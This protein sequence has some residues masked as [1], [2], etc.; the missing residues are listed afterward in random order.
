MQIFQKLA[1]YSLGAADMVRRAMSKKKEKKLAIE[2]ESF[3]NGDPERNIDGCVKRGVSA[4]IANEIFDEMMDF[5]KYAFNKSHAAAYA[6]VSYQ[7]AWLKYHYPAEYLCGMFNNKALDSYGPLY[8]DCALYGIKILPPDINKSHY[9]FVVEN[10]NIRYGFAGINGLGSKNRDFLD[11]IYIKR[12]DGAYTSF[13]DFI[14]RNLVIKE[15]ANGDDKVTPPNKD[16][17]GT[18][19]DAGCFDTFG[20][21]RAELINSM[22]FFSAL[23]EPVTNPDSENSIRNA[24]NSVTIPM[25]P[26]DHGY[27]MEKEMELLKTIV[28]ENQLD[29]YLDDEAYDCTPINSLKPK[30]SVSIFGMVV[31]AELKKS[32]RGNNMILMKIQGKTGSCTVMAMNMLYDEYAEHLEKLERHVVKIIGSVNDGGTMFANIIAELSAWKSNAFCMSLK[33]EEEIRFVK[34]LKK[35]ERERDIEVAVQFYY[36]V[37]KATHTYKR[38]D[39]PRI[40]KSF[41]S[42]EELDMISAKGIQIMEWENL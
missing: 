20:Y 25:T 19:I 6:L 40:G 33:T 17:M 22:T 34:D 7:T 11:E 13:Q 4:E 2:R 27:N 36:V 29:K 30:K 31:S 41:F 12:K 42:K 15:K 39:V 14:N 32:S 9:D 8:E 16:M 21:N 24:V 3:V 26:V 28:S 1:G 18:L 35:E 37:S 10:N 38:V 5:A 23:S